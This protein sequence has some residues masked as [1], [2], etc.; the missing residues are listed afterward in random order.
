MIQ[1]SKQRPKKNLM[2]H[3]KKNCVKKEQ[4]DVAQKVI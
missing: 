2:F 1:H 3:K 4:F